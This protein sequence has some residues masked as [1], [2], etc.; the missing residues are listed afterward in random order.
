[1]RFF[2][3]IKTKLKDFLNS[4]G[5][6]GD[7]QLKNKMGLR[8]T[9]LIV[10]MNYSNNL[11][12]EDAFKAG[13]NA[14]KSKITDLEEDLQNLILKRYSLHANNY[15]TYKENL[16]SLEHK[17]F[18]K[19]TDTKPIIKNQVLYSIIKKPLPYSATEQLMSAE[20]REIL[21]VVRHERTLIVAREIVEQTDFCLLSELMLKY[22]VFLNND[23]LHQLIE[24]AKTEKRNEK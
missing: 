1:M 11:T 19:L 23:R 2:I 16:S 3:Y 22:F 8:K 4:L 12:K 7:R 6:L 21:K 9:I 5:S 14:L 10:Y 20:Y 13:Y 15:L 18:M 24:G 17:H